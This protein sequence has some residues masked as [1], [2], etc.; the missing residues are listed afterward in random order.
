MCDWMTQSSHYFSQFFFI[1][2]SI[3]ILVIEIEAIFKNWLKNNVLHSI[4]WLMILANIYSNKGF[5]IYTFLKHCR[6][7]L[8]A[9]VEKLS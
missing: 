4:D 3:T 9:C 8:L 7:T 6:A 1:N 2:F 5:L